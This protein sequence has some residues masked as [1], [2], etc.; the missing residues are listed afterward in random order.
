ME[1]KVS[2][3]HAVPNIEICHNKGG[4]AQKGIITNERY[5][6]QGCDDN[7]NGQQDKKVQA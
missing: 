5:I 4:V 2:I 1:E 7:K 6:V 3:A